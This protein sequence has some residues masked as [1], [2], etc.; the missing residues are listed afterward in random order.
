[1]KTI[2]LV[3]GKKR[4]GKDTFFNI[5]SVAGIENIH[6]RKFAAPMYETVNTA[7][8]YEI[9]DDNK[10]I[11]NQK[12]GIAPRKWMQ[13]YG[14][15]MKRICGT[16]IFAKICSNDIDASEDGIFVITDCRF[17]E[18]IDYIKNRFENVFSILVRRGNIVSMDEHISE[19]LNVKTDFMI[20]NNKDLG[21]Y[22]DVV[23]DWYEENIGRG[24]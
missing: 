21:E 19:K 1:M 9:N 8:G 18:E 15:M 24:L 23:C 7:F 5:L 17:Q 4:A 14:D 3:C 2:I 13:E 16:D 12:L 22:A 11:V 10:E 20:E 6:K